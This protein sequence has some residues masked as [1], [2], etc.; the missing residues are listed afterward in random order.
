[1]SRCRNHIIANSTFSWWAA[2]LNMNKDKIVISP[3]IFKKD[4]CID[5]IFDD[6]VKISNI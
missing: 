2:V 3:T 1:M 6:W 5:I 4:E